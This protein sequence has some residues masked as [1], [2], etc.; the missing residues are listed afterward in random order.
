M[1]IPKYHHYVP[2]FVLRRFSSDETD[3]GLVHVFDK[4]T[5]SRFES[6]PARAF[7]SNHFYR[8]D[9]SSTTNG[10]ELTIESHLA[11]AESAVAPIIR[12]FEATPRRLDVEAITHVI[13]FVALQFLRSPG[14]RLGLEGIHL[15]VLE[16]DLRAHSRNKASRRRWRQKMR[17]SE[18]GL[19]HTEPDEMLNQLTSGDFTIRS[20]DNW[21]LA[22]SFQM[23]PLLIHI[24]S[25]RRWG[26][27]RL[28]HQTPLAIPDS[29][30]CL[31]P[32]ANKPAQAVGLLDPYTLLA[33]PLSS[34]FALLS[35]IPKVQYP[36]CRTL[37]LMINSCGLAMCQRQMI[38]TNPTF[39]FTLLDGRDTDWNDWVTR[40]G[41]TPE[42]IDHRGQLAK[43]T[44]RRDASPGGTD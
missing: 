6:T 14:W 13:H 2:R 42:M 4:T 28:T 38:A 18:R 43:F 39:H 29:G 15:S 12:D 36:S 22:L 3:T 31:I 44:E 26:F 5:K 41:V 23:L 27:A 40:G 24:L 34:N 33:F 16:A 7:A 9:S 8:I 37:A 25:K 35:T 17:F 1:S 19:P 30:L 10:D 21:K 32:M 20:D 11:N